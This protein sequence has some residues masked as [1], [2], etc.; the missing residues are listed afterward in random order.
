MFEVVFSRDFLDD[1]GELAYGDIGL[2]TL[3]SDA[4]VQYRFLEQYA[5][6]VAPEQIADADGLDIIFPHVTADTFARGAQR[7]VCIGRC[8]A[9]YDRVDLE[10]CTANDVAVFSAPEAMA[11]PTA[12]GSLT[13]MLALSKRLFALDRIVRAGDWETRAALGG[14]ELKGRTLGIVGLGHSGRKLAQLA[15]P[16]EM[17]LLAY[18]PHADP[19][20]ARALGV[21][22]V[23]LERLLRESDFVCLHCRLTTATRGLI[24][25]AELALM[26]PS[27][28][29][30]NMARGPV[31][32]HTALVGALQQG[33]IAGAGIDVFHSEPLPPADPL[34]Q[35]DNVILS[36]HWLAGTRD[37]YLYAGT[38]NCKN[39]LRAA[40]GEV[41]HNIVNP[42]V[43]E[44]PGFQAKLARFRR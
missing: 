27:A 2:A 4:H 13:L 21:Q 8:G 38:S 3:D 16:F 41:P 14:F 11:L 20:P 31:V 19:Q 18:S 29:L 28:Y 33:R 40:R 44:R 24:G 5:D 36:P 23:A 9:G 25:A 37:V 39:M 10:L 34:T 22:L 30:V 35:L 26:K 12:A 7:L 1:R 6:P 42:A 15:A 32:D 17:Q 43:L